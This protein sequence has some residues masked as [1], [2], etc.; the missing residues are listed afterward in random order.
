MARCPALPCPICGHTSTRVVFVRHIDEAHTVRRRHCPECDHRWYT[1]QGR[2]Q[3][4]PDWRV[5][6]TGR[7]SI[8]LL[9]DANA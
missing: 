8:D 4:V 5:V 3:T 2:E 6:W 1:A 9:P 7:R